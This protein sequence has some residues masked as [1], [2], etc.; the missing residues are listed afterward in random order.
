MEKEKYTEEI[1][2]MANVRMTGGAGVKVVNTQITWV[3]DG[4]TK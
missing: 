4:A 3:N 1:V 2:K